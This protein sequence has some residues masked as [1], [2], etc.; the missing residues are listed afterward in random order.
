M[1]LHGSAKWA[2]W[3]ELQRSGMAKPGGLFLGKSKGSDLYHHSSEHILTIAPPG[4][5]KTSNLIV[6][7]LL[8]YTGSVVVTDPKAELAPMTIEARR[9]MGQRIVIL[10]PWREQLRQ[11]SGIDLPDSGFNPLGHLRD[12]YS[13][14]DNVRM[15]GQLLCPTRSDEK[16]PFWPNNARSML[17]GLL[18]F[19]VKSGQ[20]VTL[21][22]L[23]SLVRG[24][25]EDMERLAA[26]M[27]E[28]ADR[29]GYPV[30]AEYAREMIGHL[31]SERQ[32]AGV[33]GHAL[34]ST[35]IYSEGDPLGLHVSGSGF[36]PADLK[37]GNMSVYIVVPQNR[38]DDAKSWLSLVMAVLGEA[39]GKPGPKGDVLF[40]AEEFGNIGKVGNI[41]RMLAEY[42]AAGLRCWLVCQTYQQLVMTYGKDGAEN[43]MA[44][45]AVKQFFGVND[46][47][48][49]QGISQRLGPYTATATSYG[50]GGG[51]SEP[52]GGGKSMLEI[53]IPQTSTNR[54]VNQ[55][56]IGVPLLRPEEIMNRPRDR[57]IILKQGMNPIDGRLVFYR[58]RSAWAAAAGPNPY[59]GQPQQQSAGPWGTPAQPDQPAF[60][61]NFDGFMNILA[62]TFIG[63]V[64]G[65]FLA[66]FV[67]RSLE[68]A[69]TGA[70]AG[71]IVAF[72][73]AVIPQ[74]VPRL[75]RSAAF[76]EI[77]DRGALAITGATLGLI[78]GGAAGG[79]LAGLLCAALGGWL[80]YQSS[81]VTLL[82]RTG[83]AAAAPIPDWLTPVVAFG[84]IA[85]IG[86]GVYYHEQKTGQP[87]PP[88]AKPAGVLSE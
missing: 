36:N 75:K 50:A 77:T 6:P 47:A 22:R 71:A 85:A 9:R 76:D 34:M 70:V 54:S 7:A 84:L 51:S 1:A 12:D 17:R 78:G 82:K 81:I 45:C 33:Q 41:D 69:G 14:H 23:R 10:N 55:S 3:F 26:Q 49:A 35:D 56:E 88:P 11:E 58:S 13:L 4:S 25:R 31:E 20:P 46:M 86:L 40:L 73:H 61:R 87:L 68:A 19:M 29:I 21:P 42:R 39:V 74:A 48:L 16:D 65:F 57:Q 37:T 24:G 38:R 60:V 83:S 28:L 79:P 44:L 18:L 52:G 2:S 27:G 5:G 53:L 80:L 64:A 15:M 59:D 30:L 63:L 32:W 62:R 43:I 8:S 67:G 66:G 72:L